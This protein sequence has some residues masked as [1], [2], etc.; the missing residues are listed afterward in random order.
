M[1]T[2]KQKSKLS[3][4]VITRNEE[5]HLPD[6]LKTVKW[7]EEIIVVDSGSSDKTVEVAKG[8]GARVIEHKEGG[9]SDW[10]NRGLS[11]VRGE[12][13]LYI[14]AD[15]RVSNDLRHEIESVIEDNQSRIKQTAYAIPRRNIILGREMRHGGW[16]PDY[17]KRLFLK[18]K[19]KGWSGE[20]H[21]EPHF[22]G[23]LG[24]LQNPLIHI[25]EDNFEK[26]I[27]KTNEWSEIEAK[28]MYKANHPKMTILRFFSA[29]FR[30]F[31]LRMIVKT[32]FLDGAEGVIF[33]FYQVYSRLISYTKLW[34][35]QMNKAR[36]E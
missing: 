36:H 34:E 30:E 21:E 18:G 7:A 17:V 6:C 14:D 12:W 8:L 19:F 9:F 28:L 32:A 5:V 23:E 25:K 35:A 3:V 33:A 13:I 24:H 31:W 26:M 27:D 10:R 16:W 2:K 22:Q 11:E 4:V 15:E 29:G 1:N 20:L